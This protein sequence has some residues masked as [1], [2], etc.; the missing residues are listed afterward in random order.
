MM[1]YSRDSFYRFKELHD[2][3]GELALQELTRTVQNVRPGAD[4]AALSLDPFLRWRR[5]WAEAQVA[6]PFN[7]GRPCIKSDEKRSTRWRA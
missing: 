3:G 2:A 4:K 1:G 6:T 7:G 5:P